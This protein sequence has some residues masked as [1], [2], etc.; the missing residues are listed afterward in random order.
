L[1]RRPAGA[2]PGEPR[3]GQRALL[4]VQQSAVRY[5]EGRPGPHGPGLA[6]DRVGARAGHPGSREV[7]AL[8]G[9]PGADTRAQG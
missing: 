3:Y 1:E 8:S 4:L 5:R 6:P 7:R 9:I 2:L